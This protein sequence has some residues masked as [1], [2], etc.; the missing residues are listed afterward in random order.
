MVLRLSGHSVKFWSFQVRPRYQLL[1]GSMRNTMKLMQYIL[2]FKRWWRCTSSISRRSRW[3]LSEWMY[4][5]I[6]LQVAFVWM[7]LKWWRKGHIFGTTRKKCRESVTGEI[8]QH[9]VQ[10]T[11]CTDTIDNIP[12]FKAHEKDYKNKINDNNRARLFRPEQKTEEF[13]K[14]LLKRYNQPGNILF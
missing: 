12:C 4:I 3:S 8:K 13:S 6:V 10:F 2:T 9:A 14:T 5:P 7:K 11:C 1:A